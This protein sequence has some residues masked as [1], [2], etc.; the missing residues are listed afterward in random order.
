[1]D[2]WCGI[3]SLSQMNGGKHMTIRQTVEDDRISEGTNVVIKKDEKIIFQGNKRQLYETEGI[4]NLD[5][6]EY[7]IQGSGV[8][9]IIK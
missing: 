7:K 3:I 9:F 4:L 8:V 6:N 1:M 5:W 2:G